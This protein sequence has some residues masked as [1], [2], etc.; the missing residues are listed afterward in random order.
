MSMR[1]QIQYQ[2]GLLMVEANGE[3]SMAEATRAFAEILRAIGQYR[4]EKVLLD[5]RNVEGEPREYERFLYGE[6][7]AQGNRQI[8]EEHKFVPQFAYVLHEPLRD[9]DRYGETVAVNRGMKVK[10]FE[11]PE[12]ALKWLGIV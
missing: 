4:A 2:S 11:T 7:V 6:F 12:D 10:V 5:G 8:V 1:Q 9:P 3:F